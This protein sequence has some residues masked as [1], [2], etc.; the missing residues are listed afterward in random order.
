MN[1]TM[2]YADSFCEEFAGEGDFLD[3]LKKEKKT[4]LGKRSYPIR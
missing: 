1:E 3:F 2:V 4:Q